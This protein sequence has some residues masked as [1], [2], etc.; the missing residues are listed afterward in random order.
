MYGWPRF[1]RGFEGPVSGEGE[2]SAGERTGQPLN[3]ERS[4]VS[5]AD[6]VQIAEG[7]GEG[8][9]SAS[10][11]PLRGGR[12]PWHT[13]TLLGRERGG[14]TAD[15]AHCSRAT[16]ASGGR[17]PGPAAR[18]RISSSRPKMITGLED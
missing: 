16:P 3:R 2:A 18:P 15:S 1:A 4:T 13:R 11:R 5:E 10:G 7:N 8:R 17:S 14:P 6:A 12:R 9:G